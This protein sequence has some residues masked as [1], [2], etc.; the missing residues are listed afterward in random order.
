MFPTRSVRLGKSGTAAAAL[1]VLLA[2]TATGQREKRLDARQVAEFERQ[3]NQ[4][5][6]R[7][8][9]G[10]NPASESSAIAAR[11]MEN[12]RR[13]IEA[14]NSRAKG[15][16]G[17]TASD[18][19]RIVLPTPDP[20]TSPQIKSA[21]VSPPVDPGDLV[22]VIGCGFGKKEPG[23]ELRL[24]GDF[25]APIKLDVV[26][27]TGWKIVAST[28]PPGHPSVKGLKDDKN[29]KLQVHRKDGK[30]SN[31]FNVGFRAA[32]QV[33]QLR[34]FDVT[35]QC[36]Q[37]TLDT[38]TLAT[39]HP[40]SETQLYGGATFAARHDGY[41]L[42]APIGDECEGSVAELGVTRDGADSVVFQLANNFE[43]AGFAWYWWYANDSGHG[44]VFTPTVPA[45]G[46]TSGKASADWR[47]INKICTQ[48]RGG[49]K[50]RMDLW[51]IGPQGVSPK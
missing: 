3:R 5:L 1:L 34:P 11:M 30:F 16:A 2:G 47:A 42:H 9:L 28:P 15:A 21:E 40:L 48:K 8:P 36:V 32:R 33:V 46:V 17:M 26:S 41:S 20:C 38:C 50:L 25:P 13:K 6:A 45:T 29:A 22:V 23:S 39:S 24:I 27:W 35:P 10:G 31:W 14:E 19:A 18:E 51:V 4:A 37:S 44:V 43:F 7:K 12:H 49:V